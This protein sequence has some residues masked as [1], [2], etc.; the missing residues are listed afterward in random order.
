MYCTCDYAPTQCVVNIALSQLKVHSS[1]HNVQ[2]C[3]VEY[4]TV[5]NILQRRI[6]YSG[7]CFTVYMYY[8]GGNT[9]GALPPF[10]LDSSPRPPTIT[11]HPQHCTI[12]SENITFDII[13]LNDNISFKVLGLNHFFKSAQRVPRP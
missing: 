6:Y 2:C 9:V 1:Q 8:S 5:G 10:R 4:I 13:I 11:R 3:A 7:E 12:F